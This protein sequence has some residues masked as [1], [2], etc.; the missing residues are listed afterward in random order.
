MSG[1]ASTTTIPRAVSR[2]PVVVLVAILAG[3]VLGAGTGL[4]GGTSFRSTAMLVLQSPT[5]DNAS[6]SLTF[7][8]DRYVAEQVAVFD[9]EVLRESAAEIA[10][11]ELLARARSATGATVTVW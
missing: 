6:Q 10:N 7:S 2:R 11:E 8:P 4:I 5:T 1:A 3:M 9:L